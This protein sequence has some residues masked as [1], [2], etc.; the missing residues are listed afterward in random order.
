MDT[1]T[2]G[3]Q[4]DA[5]PKLVFQSGPLRG[6]VL[7]VENRRTSIGRDARNDIAIND[8]IVSSFHVAIVQDDGKFYLEDAESKNGTFLNG[9]RIRR[10]E[11]KDGDIFCLCQTGPEIQFS[12]GCPS[13]P[14]LLE[15]TTATFSRT[16]SLTRA[17]KDLFTAGSAQGTSRGLSLT[18][19]RKILDYKL[20]VATRRSRNQIVMVSGL[21]LI[22]VIAALVATIL[23]QQNALRA[24]ETLQTAP[25][26]PATGPRLQL[27]SRLEPI[28]GSL[29]LSYRDTP[30][31]E[32]DIFN[33]SLEPW[34]GGELGLQFDGAAASFL[35][36]PFVASVP[37][38]PPGGKVS[39]GVLPKLSTAVLSSQTREVTAV[40][41]LSTDSGV[42]AR[43]SSGVFVHSRNT[44][45]WERPEAI[46]AFVDHNDL[47]VREL[48]DRCWEFRPESTRDEFPPPNVV[49]A[50]TL[51]AGL[52]SLRVNYRTDSSN[53]I[54][55]RIDSKAIERVSYPG[56]TLLAKS[57]DCDDLSVLGCA[58]LEAAGIPTALA[59]GAGHVLFL[60]DS[61]VEPA[62]LTQ[63]PL[64]PETI[65]EWKGR[66]WLPV[67]ATDLARPGASFASAWAAA[68]PRCAA[69][70]QGDMRLVE[71]RDAWRSFQP[72]N[73]PLNEGQLER[74]ANDVRL[75]AQGLKARI[76]ES[77]D[78][79]LELFRSNVSSR[80][81]ELTRTLPAGL[82]REQAIGLVF[83]HSGLFGDAV[84]VLE[85]AIF[86][87]EG[88][89]A[90]GLAAW[91]REV[92][93]ALAVLLVDLLVCLSSQA[94]SAR[95]L[96]YAVACGELALK[97]FPAASRDR[98][99]LLLRV[100]LVHRLRGDLSQERAWCGRAFDADPSLSDVYKRLTAAGGPVAGPTEEILRYLRRGLR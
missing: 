56:E 11:L 51:L 28:Y 2:F 32:I 64:D 76:A 27:V 97:G 10:S 16:G 25:V 23:V 83:A 54:S 46:A 14:T 35:V 100:A 75:V 61:G 6:Q 81:D 33:K 88:I 77:S 94:R 62:H 12:L 40:A 29:Y 89:P 50:V 24:P 5:M 90:T 57:G 58:V 82:E 49:G 93:P 84:R 95:D 96:D 42:I 85:R 15:S 44:F 7:A 19:V 67:E 34:N 22:L 80:V 68:W 99:E 37:S 79:I 36:E 87:E 31:G 59:V 98:S 43:Q 48:V 13:L 53:P 3:P 26:G 4:A 20:E 91:Q 60:F 72:M 73:P 86:G 18:G 69:M 71:L 1:V 45:H 8:D 55:E 66:V 47:A 41:T 39:I 78:R 92:T 38:I 9:H 52:T 21:F 70:S 74:F 30:V 65:V 17:L 63:T